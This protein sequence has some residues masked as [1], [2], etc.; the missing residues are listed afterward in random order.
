MTTI[1]IGSLV[2]LNQ[3]QRDSRAT[4]LIDPQEF[5][6]FVEEDPEKVKEAR[7]LFQ[8][9]LHSVGRSALYP[10]SRQLV[11]LHEYS[12]GP[13]DA[14]IESFSIHTERKGNGIVR[15]NLCMVTTSEGTGF[16]HHQDFVVPGRTLKEPA[17]GDPELV[18]HWSDIQWKKFM[19]IGKTAVPV[20]GR[21]R[22]LS[23]A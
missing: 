7:E 9:T 8:T 5:E 18:R 21:T 3:S 6:F 19:E 11:S 14:T 23:V 15:E 20:R 12:E 10:V 1:E 2:E 22:A 16:E 4:G 17:V 13:L